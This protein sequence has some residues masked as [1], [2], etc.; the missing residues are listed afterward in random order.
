M[1][2]RLQLDGHKRRAPACY[3]QY[4][5]LWVASRLQSRARKQAE[6]VLPD[7]GS[8]ENRF[9]MRDDSDGAEATEVETAL[10]LLSP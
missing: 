2:S 3:F 4:D 8:D 6:N 10:E 9:Q 1:P 5:R 7:I